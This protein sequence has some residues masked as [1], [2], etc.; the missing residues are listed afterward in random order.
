V[1]TYA[2][3]LN[4]CTNVLVVDEWRQT[5]GKNRFSALQTLTDIE[6]DRWYLPQCQ[7]RVSHFVLP[8]N[9]QKITHVL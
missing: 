1:L 2:V 6:R 3:L 8:T 7:Q 9:V 4:K 5:A